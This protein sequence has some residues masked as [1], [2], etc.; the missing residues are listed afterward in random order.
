MNCSTLPEGLLE[1]E[2]FGHCSGA[3]SGAVRDSAGLLQQADRGTLFLDELDKASP[4]LQAKL[5]RFLDTGE[6]RRVGETRMRSVS[7]RVIAATSRDPSELVEREE[8]LPDLLFRIRGVEIHLLPLRKRQ[9]DVVYLARSFLREGNRNGKLRFSPDALA[10]LKNYSWPGNVRELK[11]EVE[12][13][14]LFAKDGVID[15]HSFGPA[16]RGTREKTNGESAGD[17]SLID[18]EK[19]TI[20]SALSSA[21]GNISRAAETLGIARSTLYHKIRRL[22][23]R[24]S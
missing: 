15:A 24:V 20:L 14:I 1:S 4:S 13:S 7:V 5:L 11:A 9:G 22:G 2:L 18:Q 21:K 10:L 16:I 17:S 12:R 6:I 23:I 3:F 8:F 19:R